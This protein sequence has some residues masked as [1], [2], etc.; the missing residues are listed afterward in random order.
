[1][2]ANIINEVPLDQLKSH[3]LIQ[4]WIQRTHEN[5][6]MIL[7]DKYD[8]IKV[9]RVIN[10]S[11]KHIYL[12]KMRLVN[13][14][15]M[16]EFRGTLLDMY[17]FIKLKKPIISGNGVL[18]MQHGV[19][20]N[21]QLKWIADLMAKRKGYKK[22]MFKC[23]EDSP[24]YRHYD[25]LQL[26]TKIKINSLY[27]VLG[28]AKFMLYNIFLA[29][30]V[31]ATGQNIISSVAC[32]FESFICDDLGFVTMAEIRRFVKNC[33]AEANGKREGF[34]MDILLDDVHVPLPKD[35]DVALRIKKA[36]HFQVSEM[37]EKEIDIM[38]N[39]ADTYTK[40]LMYYKTN[41]MGIATIPYFK[42]II[43][44]FVEKSNTLLEPDIT[45]IQSEE[46]KALIELFWD[47]LQ[48]YVIYE[49]PI[50]D[51]VRRNKYEMKKAV[52][53]EDTDSNFL[54][55][56]RWVRFVQG[57]F[58]GSKDEGLR[59]TIVN[60]FGIIL[61][62][63]VA[64]TCKVL[65]DS[66]NIQPEHGKILQFKNEFYYSRILFV[67]TKKRYIGLQKIREGNLL[68]GDV[69]NMDV[70]GFDFR[71][72][73]TKPTLRQFYTQLSYEEIMI[74]DPIDNSAILRK[75]SELEQSIRDSLLSG[76]TIYYKQAQVKRVSEYAYPYRIPGVKAVLLWNT[77]NPEYQ[78]E[79]PSDVDIVPIILE[80]GRR[81]T[82]KV[83]SGVECI[84]VG[85]DIHGNRKYVV[86][87]TKTILEFGRKYPEAY[88]RLDSKIL[89]NE[90][91]NIRDLK[92]NFIA[93][94]KNP[95]IPIPPWFWDIINYDQIINDSLKLYNPILKTLGVKIMKTGPKTEHYTN[96][97]S[98]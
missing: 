54:S 24:E 25:L 65:T 8:P 11:L 41:L 37:M 27:G 85:D 33:T 28:Y 87:D 57:M 74:K 46:A 4:D 23:E 7:G 60:T 68:K 13:N 42:N 56:N 97:I 64:L 22:E 67:N 30:S 82:T 12:P 66:M 38:V 51:R 98:L 1:M 29:Q 61:G 55:L 84:Y 16:K 94:P 50:Y 39:Q 10:E 88:S 72:S 5:F 15:E 62:R 58:G 78:I 52:L 32:G 19:K 2:N 47:Y 95:A 83:L 93:K 9:E 44:D 69:R 43:H 70:K 14:Y 91:P 77:L 96:M 71:K 92:L 89:R 26:N 40:K 35:E 3:L 73:V 21:P 31:T 48:T 59:Y 18:F 63:N 76:D 6:K 90:N 20:P 49:Y 79:L 53:Y 36:C 45:K 81:R 75:I 34:R 17:D 86:N 80:N